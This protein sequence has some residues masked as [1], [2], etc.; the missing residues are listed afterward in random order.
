MTAPAI[1]LNLDRTC[2]ECGRPGATTTGICLACAVDA[3]EG[4]TMRSAA[5]RTVQDRWREMRANITRGG[6]PR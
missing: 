5:G 3:I 2:A 4:K 6:R 1:T